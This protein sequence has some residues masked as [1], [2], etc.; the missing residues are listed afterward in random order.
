MVFRIQHRFGN[1]G[2]QSGGG[3]HT[4]YG[5]DEVSDIYMSF[6]FGIVKNLEVG[7]GRSKEQELLDVFAKYKPLTQKSKGMPISLTLY[8]D[9]AITPELNSVFYNDADTSEYSKNTI[10]RLM[11]DGEVIIDRRFGA[12]LSF[13]IFA[14]YNHRNYVL[15][16]VNPEN[17]ATDENNIPYVG[18]AAKIALTKRSSIIIEGYYLQS[19]YRTN[20][21]NLGYYQPISIGY[22]IETGGHVFEINFSNANYIDVNNFIPNTTDNW[23]KGGFKLGFSISRLFNI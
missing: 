2:E 16:L 10:D 19:A 3:I 20:N 23:A 22:E 13:E 14:G 4:L 9:V 18:A 21:S 1:A 5:F 12:G 11:Y 7:A 8:A 15:G 17:N 6:E